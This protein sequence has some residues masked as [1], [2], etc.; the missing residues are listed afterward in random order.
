MRSLFAGLQLFG[1]AL[2]LPIAVL[3]IAGLLLRLGQ[4]DL[5]DLPAVA[6]AG[7]AIFSNLGIL[8]AIGISVG[9][10]RENHG[11]AALAAVVCYFVATRGAEVLA[12]VVAGSMTK[13]SVPAGLLCGCIAGLLYN[14]YSEI[15]LPSYLAFFGGRRFVPIVAGVAGLLLAA[16]FG[17][18]WP[19]LERGMDG[20]SRTVLDAGEIG[21][22]IYGVLNRVLIITG[23]HHVL[24][25]LAWFIVGEYGGVTGDLNRFFAGDPTAGVFMSGFFPV[26]MFGLPAACL[27]MYHAAPPGR[28]RAV[29]GLMLS[30]ALTSFL[31]GVTEPIEFTFV[32]LA[33]ALYALHALLTGT[34]MVL[35]D[36][37][38]VR[39][40]FG[41]SAG[42]FDYLLN[43]G[44]ATNPLLMLPV[45][46]LYSVLYYVT[47][48]FVIARF[49][50]ATPGR[51]PEE[52]PVASAGQASGDGAA[53]LRALGGAA[54]VRAL[55]ACTTRLRVVVASQAAVD[56]AAL[57][58]LGA[59]GLIRPTA[60]ALQVVVGPVADQ[61]A[62]DI[63]RSLRGASSGAQA[64]TDGAALLAALGGSSN[65]RGIESHATRILIAI[66]DDA[67][68]D[69]AAL[70]AAAP[71]GF[72]RPSRGS[73]HVIVG[74]AAAS[75]REALALLA[76]A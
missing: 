13:L 40:G 63:R 60:D 76:S 67:R 59:R 38:G 5:L 26:M 66:A 65:L 56:D 52:A 9:I 57:K 35:M 3:P 12:G 29:G 50:L 69:E 22:F 61:L 34:A 8:F 55:D 45:G 30:M 72:A 62:G 41:F 42:L 7:Q 6:A 64:T 24:N 31:T 33:P 18:G 51:E 46:L 47:F 16:A 43:Y 53:F 75:A 23:L 10:A 48:R 32:F 4:P 58:A 68:V 37:L 20:L 27:A 25:N 73:V 14:R 49:G 44:K 70:A 21:L 39:L 15:R 74:P 1:R 36:L 71:R 17:F 11:A 54:N 19:L 28:R 2:M